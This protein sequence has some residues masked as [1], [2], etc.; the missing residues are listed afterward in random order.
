MPQWIL[1]SASPR[2]K[3]LLEALGLDIEVWPADVTERSDGAPGELVISNARLK[4]DAVAL[5]APAAARIIAADTVVTYGDRVLGKPSDMDEARRMLAALSGKTHRVYTGL[6]VTDTGQ[7][8]SA[9]TYEVTEVTFRPLSG[10][11]I[12]AFVE[13]VQPL[14]RAGAYTVDGPGSLLVERYS[15]CYQ[16]VLGLPLVRLDRLL[17]SIG[18]SL[19][20]CINAERATFL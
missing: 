2:R 17:E 8:R 15:G 10:A 13:A 4:R 3:A 6:A 7:G 11:M 12:E 19:F 5:R 18:L 1:A 14:D 9:E 20:S 16:N